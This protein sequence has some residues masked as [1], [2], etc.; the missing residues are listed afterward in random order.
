VIRR[1]KEIKTPSTWDTLSWVERV[2]YYGGP[3]FIIWLFYLIYQTITLEYNMPGI[4][5]SHIEETIDVD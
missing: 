4:L 1:G 2:I 5:E 3:I